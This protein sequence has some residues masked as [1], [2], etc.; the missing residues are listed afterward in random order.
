MTELFSKALFSFSFSI[1]A[2]ILIFIALVIVN[3]KWVR[4]INYFFT[5]TLL[6]PI[7]YVITKVISNNLALSLG[8]IG[9][10]SI[11][12]FRN[13]VKSPLELVVYFSLIT[14]GI[15]MGVDYKWSLLLI[16]SII[17]ILFITHFFSEGVKKITGYN[18]FD[19]NFNTNDNVQ[20]S[21][22]EIESA[23]SLD[24]IDNSKYLVFFSKKDKLNNYKLVFNDRISLKKFLDKL[25]NNPKIL[26]IEI[27][28][29]D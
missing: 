22:L 1:V 20:K 13:P 6:P 17:S 15:S 24:I 12:R 16:F 25:N 2:G 21:I 7:T 10:L 23:E 19:Y 28:Y 11:V 5:F 14:V 18:L 3:Q 29:N 27:Q 4:T 8:M 9:A 26:N